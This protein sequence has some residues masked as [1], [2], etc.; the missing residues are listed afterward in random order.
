MKTIKLKNKIPKN[1]H[2][3]I[4][5]KLEQYNDAKF[6]GDLDLHSFYI[7]VQMI[8]AVLKK[9]KAFE[10]FGL[11]HEEEMIRNNLYKQYGRIAFKKADKKVKIELLNHQKPLPYIRE[12]HQQY[13]LS[14]RKSE[15]ILKK[16]ID[17]DMKNIVNPYFEMTYGISTE[18][19]VTRGSGLPVVARTKS[20]FE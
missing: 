13:Y 7:C 19:E 3:G 9:L 11:T 10:T 20:S 1:I 15:I 8:T 12:F 17:L 4:K 18:M 6:R 16:L 14:S 2:W 5:N